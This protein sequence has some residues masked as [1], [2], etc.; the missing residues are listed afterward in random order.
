MNSAP[1]AE[2]KRL[3]W[4]SPRHQV[5][6]KQGDVADMPAFPVRVELQRGKARR[7]SVIPE[8]LRGVG[9]SFRALPKRGAGCRTLSERKRFRI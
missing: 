7:R 1:T 9:F 5:I 8:N 6:I 3:S 4:P 2:G